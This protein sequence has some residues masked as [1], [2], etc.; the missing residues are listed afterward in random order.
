MARQLVGMTQGAKKRWRRKGWTR[1][2]RIGERL[3][4]CPGCGA[5]GVQGY[6]CIPHFGDLT[7]YLALTPG[8]RRLTIARL[9][10]APAGPAH[11]WYTRGRCERFVSDGRWR[12][13]DL[14]AACD[15][16]GVLPARRA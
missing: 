3:R 1:D 14:P 7:D 12:R 6:R 9:G 2:L 8:R 4:P 15:G 5:C 11:P 10:G 13:V 16:S